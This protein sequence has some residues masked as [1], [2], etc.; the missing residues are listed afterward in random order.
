M[1]AIVTHIVHAQDASIRFSNYEK[2]AGTDTYKI[3]VTGLNGSTASINDVNIKAVKDFLK[4]RKTAED[5]HWYIDARGYFV[6]YFVNGN[7]GWSFYDKKGNFV[8][9]VQTLT[10]KSLPFEVRDLVKRIYYADYSIDF[11]EEVQTDGNTV[12]VVNISN[13]KTI[14]ILNIFDGE[15]TVLKDLIKSR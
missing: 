8:Y 11:A 15:I 9:N 12:F 14:K 1:A 2:E 3:P 7:K 10:E 4:S 6:Y 5:S 13:D